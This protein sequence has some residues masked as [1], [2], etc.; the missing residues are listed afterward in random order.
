MSRQVLQ[1]IIQ[2]ILFFEYDHEFKKK[3]CLRRRGDRDYVNGLFTFVIIV[4]LVETF[5]F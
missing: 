1:L 5:I 4:K 2:Q 3:K